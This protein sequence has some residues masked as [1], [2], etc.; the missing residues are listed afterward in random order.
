[1]NK[2]IMNLKFEEKDIKNLKLVIITYIQN[3]QKKLFDNELNDEQ[4][5][6]YSN[7]II[8]AKMLLA[9]IRTCE[10][11]NCDDEIEFLE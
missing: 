3:Y 6:M 1:M 2:K 9:K 4:R 8:K 5:D 11:Y 7:E 10:L